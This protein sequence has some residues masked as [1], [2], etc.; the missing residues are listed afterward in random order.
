M[1]ITDHLPVYVYLERT[2]NFRGLILAPEIVAYCQII[3]SR[4]HISEIIL[5]FRNMVSIRK[6][7][8]P[9][10]NMQEVQASMFASMS[11]LILLD[12]SHNL[13]QHLPKFIF[14]PLQN[15]QYISLHH[16]LISY[17]H[18][19]VFIYTANV[20]VLLLESNN[21]NP[22]IVTIDISLP[23][24]YRF[25]SDIPRICCA[26]ETVQFCSP[27]FALI[28]SCSNMIASIFQMAIAWLIG[29]ITSFLNLVC[30]EV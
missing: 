30:V 7:L 8:L 21:I 24:L 13:I 3:H 22:K 11:E 18:N 5:L 26:F 12:L 20:Q 23:F 2:E 25:S 29:L 19:D 4:F 6:L 9:R 28:I 14:C 1:N 15:L 16:N 10:N 17:V 27:P